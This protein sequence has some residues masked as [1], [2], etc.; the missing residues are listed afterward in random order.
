MASLLP[1][2]STAQLRVKKEAIRLET[3]GVHAPTPS[4]LSHPLTARCSLHYPVHV[5]AWHSSMGR[6]AQSRGSAH[7]DRAGAGQCQKP[8]S[9]PDVENK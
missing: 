5:F 2:H 4:A 6:P 1:K 7:V 3:G 9:S 8:G